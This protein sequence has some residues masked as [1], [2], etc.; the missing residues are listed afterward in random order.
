MAIVLLILMIV[1]M[2]VFLFSYFFL[3]LAAAKREIQLCT[4]LIKQDE[5]IRQAETKSMKKSDAITSAS[6]DVRNALACMTE[7]IKISCN[8]VSQG[9]EIKK[10]LTQMDACTKHL[11]GIL[12]SI[13]DKSKI[14][15]G[16]MVLEDEEFDIFQLVEEVI[17]FFLPSGLKKG[18]D[19]VL[20][21]YD[22]SL[23]KFAHVSG[24]RRRLKQILCNLLGNAVK[25]TSEG[26]VTVRAWV[27][28]PTF[29]VFFEQ[30]QRTVRWH[31]SSDWCST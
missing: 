20:D 6:H 9:S 10:Y 21:P 14:E 23:L 7:L 2:A 26:Q 25:F 11:L 3:M 16:K 12:N 28:K 1:I 30:D 19:V 27:Q 4:K 5:A 13:L 24:D 22:C 29:V 15:A 8:E 31:K 18:I 17:D